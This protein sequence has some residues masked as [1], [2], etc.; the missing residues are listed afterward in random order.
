MKCSL[1]GGAGWVPDVIDA[2]TLGGACCPSCK[3]SGEALRKKDGATNVS[4]GSESSQAR[5]ENEQAGAS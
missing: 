4:V 3:G 2:L 1:C 5:S